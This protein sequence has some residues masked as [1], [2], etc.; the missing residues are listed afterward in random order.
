[1]FIRGTIFRKKKS[2]WVNVNKQ[3][4]LQK[5]RGHIG[6]FK[7]LN[8]SIQG[9][10]HLFSFLILRNHMARVI[11][12]F[13][14]WKQ[15]YFYFLRPP[16]YQLQHLSLC[17]GVI[18]H[19]ADFEMQEKPSRLLFFFSLFKFWSLAMLLFHKVKIPQALTCE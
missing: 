3:A 13:N 10:F 8:K 1:M 6:P 7:Y 19:K 4:H 14:F 2:S 15:K 16:S 5:Y 17:S 18:Q 9:I 12:L 11:I